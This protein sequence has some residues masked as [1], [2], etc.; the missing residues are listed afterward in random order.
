MNGFSGEIIIPEVPRGVLRT[1]NNKTGFDLQDPSWEEI[2]QEVRERLPR[3]L[4]TAPGIVESEVRKRLINQLV[5][6]DERA[7][8]HPNLTEAGDLENEE[9]L[10]GTSVK[11]DLVRRTPDGRTE[12]YELK[13]GDATPKDIYQLLMYWDGELLNGT[14]PDVG[15]LVTRSYTT[16]MEE[17][18]TAINELHGCNL[19]LQTLEERRLV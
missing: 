4:S 15:Y 6:I 17:M 1:V 11:P 19:V 10:F 9:L 12:I 2:F 18:C 16:E 14:Q 3:P 7:E 8:L 13:V 5:Y